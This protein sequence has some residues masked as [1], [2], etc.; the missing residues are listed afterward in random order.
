LSYTLLDQNGDP[1]EEDVTLKETISDFSG[2]QGVKPTETSIVMNAGTADDV[3]GYNID[4]CP[5]P[6]TATMTQGFK[7]VKGSTTY[8]LTT[9]N[10]ISMGRRSDGT[11]FVDVTLH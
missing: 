10:S 8:N 11:K 6:F 2:P 5:P 9:T 1:I 3:V 4:T 7:V